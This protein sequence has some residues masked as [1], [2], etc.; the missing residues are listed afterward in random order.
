[1]PSAK[2]APYFRVICPFMQKRCIHNFR[3]TQYDLFSMNIHQKF[4]MS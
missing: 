1:M 2:I 4:S 3:R